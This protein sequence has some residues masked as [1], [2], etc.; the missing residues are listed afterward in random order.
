MLQRV[1]YRFKAAFIKISIHI[2]II[3]RIRRTTIKLSKQKQN[4]QFSCGISK[5]KTKPKATPNI[6]N[7]L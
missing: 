7:K 3:P 1:F 4:Q 6:Q 2:D 5:N